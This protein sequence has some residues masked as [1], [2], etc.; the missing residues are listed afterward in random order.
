MDLKK[1][2]RQIADFPK[3]G[4]NFFDISTLLIHPVAMLA[5]VICAIFAANEDGVSFGAVASGE[6]SDDQAS[7][8]PSGVVTLYHSFDKGVAAVMGQAAALEAHKGRD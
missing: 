2:V 3:P 1:H 4:I 5:M 8:S 7:G 6:S